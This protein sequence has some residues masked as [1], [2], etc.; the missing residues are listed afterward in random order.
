M[1]RAAL[2]ALVTA[3]LT[4]CTVGVWIGDPGNPAVVVLGDSIT[5]NAQ[6]SPQ[7]DDPDTHH[8]TDDLNAAGWYANVTGWVGLRAVHGPETI[9]EI[10]GPTPTATV[11]ALGTNDMLNGE[12]IPDIVAVM[13]A[14]AATVPCIVFVGVAEAAFPNGEAAALNLALADV[15]AQASGFFVPWVPEPEWVTPDF[16]HLTAAGEPVF[17]ALVVGAAELCR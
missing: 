13:S 2:V 4:S 7:D 1:K 17:R 14:Y 8:L 15:A 10:G 5:W 12:T 9:A 11:V 3:L 6:G 16:I